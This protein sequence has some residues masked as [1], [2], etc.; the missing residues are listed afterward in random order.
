MLDWIKRR[1]KRKGIAF[2]LTLD[3]VRSAIESGVCEVTGIKFDLESYGPK[4]RSPWA[5]SVDRINP[6]LGYTDD[7][8]RVV[9]TIY[10]LAKSNFKADDLS[11]LAR[12]I[13]G[14]EAS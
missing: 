12:A 3:R 13:V 7:N 2:T 10:N 11:R 5:P 1:A 8:V 6:E 14:S 9:V 4:K